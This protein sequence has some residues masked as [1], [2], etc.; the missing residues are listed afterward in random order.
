MQ[1]LGRKVIGSALALCMFGAVALPAA[2]TAA[3]GPLPQQWWFHTWGVND[4]LWPATKGD[5]V[6]V[7]V[8]DTG[9]QANVP[10]LRG[11]VLRGQDAENGGGDGRTDLD[12]EELGGHGTA[13]A[14][15]IAAQGQGTGMVGVA[16]QAKILPIV[17]QSTAA[18]AKGIRF[19]ADQG[20]Q[21]VNLSQAVPGPCPEDLQR[22]IAYAINKD[23][24]IVAGAGN[25]GEGA[26]SPNSPANCAGVLAVGAVDQQFKPWE[27]TQRQPYVT[28][29]APGV[30]T[31][32]VVKNGSLTSGSGT[33]AASA[34]TSG[35]VA[36]LRAKFP[37]MS[38]REL[39]RQLVASAL[40]ISEKG[41]DNRTGY[42]II[43][44]NRVLT[45]KAPKG[46]T[47]PVFDKYDNWAKLH[48]E[49]GGSPVGS[50]ND[51]ERSLGYGTII[52]YVSI[53]L[54]VVAVCVF[55]FFFSR[56]KRGPKPSPHVDALGMPS[57][58]GGP[59]EVPPQAGGQLAGRPPSGQPQPPV[60]P[61]E[62][63]PGSGS[64]DEPRG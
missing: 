43:R 54:A 64:S 62:W 53:A 55:G 46:T 7:A 42:G 5:G 32:V 22:A 61:G 25:D 33:S 38:N 8:I 52:G 18:Y 48:K 19:A 31:S 57:T 59:S 49:D 45:G 14:S 23:V 51:G 34:L 40:D 56:R 35:A 2:A 21:V 3:P 24:V 13:M 11:V 15:L 60:R 12:R 30:R 58:F 17:G 41:K 4:L 39:V 63:P 28:V 10:D 29:A 44:P 47:N 9:V 16:P 20:A 6:T 36:L 27:K 1:E 26:N 50:N 37:D